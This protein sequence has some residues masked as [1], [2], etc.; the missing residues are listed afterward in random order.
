MG[1]ATMDRR[2]AERTT[3]GAAS[4]VAYVGAAA[5]VIGGVWYALATKGVLMAPA[6]TPASGAS[7]KESQRQFFA[8]FVTTLHQERLYTGLAIVGFLCLAATAAFVRDLLG[9]DRAVVRIATMAITIG[10]TLWIVGNVAHLGA[11]RAVGLLSTHA[12]PTATSSGILLT[13]DVID[14]AFEVAAFAALGVGSLLLA[15]AATHT[16]PSRRGWAWL[17][18]LIGV[19]LI[20]TVASYLFPVGDLTDLLLMTEGTLLVPAWLIWCGRLV[21]G[22]RSA[23]FLH[24]SEA[25]A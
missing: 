10:A 8:W 23:A 16:Q 1:T 19:A 25:A 2:A 20:G 14:D 9:R 18:F 11:H 5:F 17:T 12:S 21:G 13:F 7:V 6:P 22:H 3:A 15:R 4:V 24:V